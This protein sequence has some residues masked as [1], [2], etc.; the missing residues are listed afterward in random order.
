MPADYP[1]LPQDM[2]IIQKLLI[3]VNWRYHWILLVGYNSLMLI[4]CVFKKCCLYVQVYEIERKSRILV[5][6]LYGW[7]DFFKKCHGNDWVHMYGML[8]VNSHMIV[9]YL[10]GSSNVDLQ[11]RLCTE[12]LQVEI[13]SKDWCMY[14]Y[15]YVC[16]CVY[17]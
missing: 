13:A 17:L 11:G 12:S 6:L 1:C 5:W 4:F 8:I 16:V 3:P 14:I 15:I 10:Q 7:P 9:L 2:T